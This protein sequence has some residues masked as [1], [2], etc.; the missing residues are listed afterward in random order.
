MF[1]MMMTGDEILVR[2][3]LSHSQQEKDEIQDDQTQTGKVGKS[4]VDARPG[5]VR[6]GRGREGLKEH[7]PILF[8]LLLMK[9]LEK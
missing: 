1:P 3:L 4:V 8:S 7:L 9:L 6:K 2:G 5:S